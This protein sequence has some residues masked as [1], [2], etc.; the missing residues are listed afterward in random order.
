[1]S[2]KEDKSMT[3]ADTAAYLLLVR[4]LVSEDAIHRGWECHSPDTE[5]LQRELLADL[6]E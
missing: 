6:V 3:K 4:E 2:Q 1:M 5:L